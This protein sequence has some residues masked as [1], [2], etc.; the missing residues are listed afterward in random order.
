M[1]TLYLFW[2]EGVRCFW[3]LTWFLLGNFVKIVF[4]RSGRE[5]TTT[6][7]KCGGLSATAAKAPP[8]VE[9]TFLESGEENGTEGE[10]NGTD[11]SKI[12][13]RL[14]RWLRNDG[15]RASGR[16]FMGDVL[17]GSDVGVGTCV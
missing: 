12:K 13:R 4:G 1:R 5:Q 16:G 7:A 11:S 8:S 9:M 6:K 10:E 3:G 2:G 17:W 14:V 15:R